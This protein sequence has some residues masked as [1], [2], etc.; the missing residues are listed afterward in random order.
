[1]G[2]FC[3][4]CSKE[5]DENQDLCDECQTEVEHDDETKNEEDEAFVLGW[6]VLGFFFPIIGIILW[7]LWIGTKPRAS[8]ASG[9]GVLLGIGFQAL[10]LVATLSTI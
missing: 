7:M 4:S 2:K 5:I 8:N 9:I 6:G 3:Y 1:M 10:L